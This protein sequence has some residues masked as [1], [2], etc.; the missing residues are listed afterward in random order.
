MLDI[1]IMDIVKFVNFG[2]NF[3][4]KGH[5]FRKN[6]NQLYPMPHPNKSFEKHGQDA[7][8]ALYRF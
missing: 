3:A 7:E 1:V 2:L 4:Q 5:A 6:A 8:S